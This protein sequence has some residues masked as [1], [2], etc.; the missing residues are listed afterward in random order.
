MLKNLYYCVAQPDVERIDGIPRVFSGPIG[1]SNI[2]VKNEKLREKLRDDHKVK[3]IE[4]EGSGIADGTL[5]HGMGVFS[6]SE[7]FELLQY[8]QK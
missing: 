7:N 1:S 4:M 3:A 8:R 2:L 5:E 6:C